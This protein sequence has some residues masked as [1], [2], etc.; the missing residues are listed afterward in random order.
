MVRAVAACLRGGARGVEV[1]ERG[2]SGHDLLALALRLRELTRQAGAVL[3]V[4]ERADVALAAEADGVR[5]GRGALPAPAVRKLARRLTPSFLIGRSVATVE[6]AALAQLEE[7]DFLVFS[8]VWPEPC[9]DALRA[10]VA[11]VRRPVLAGGGIT[12][13]RVAALREVGVAGLV[14]GREALGGSH[15]EGDTARFLAAWRAGGV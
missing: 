14:L 4:E 15:P 9:L 12:P 8:P 10:V 5:L 13:E 1:A 2:L 11:S 6:E 7:A 3:L